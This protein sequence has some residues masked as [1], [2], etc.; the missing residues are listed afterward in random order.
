FEDIKKEEFESIKGLLRPFKESAT[1]ALKTVDRMLTLVRTD[2]SEADDIGVYNINDCVD[3]TLKSY[4]LSDQRL[5]RINVNKSN[6]F[7][8]KGSKHFVSHVISNLI[9]NALKYAGPQ[10]SIEIWYKDHELHFADNGYGIEPERVSC[11]FDPF[12]RQGNTIGTGIGLPFCRKVMESMG[13][14]IECKST[15]GKGAE[16]ILKFAST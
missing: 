11:I 5:A 12:D 1:A 16:F 7:K 15:L 14:S 13:G 2:I 8:F 4:G 3:A 9:S 10:S 6:S